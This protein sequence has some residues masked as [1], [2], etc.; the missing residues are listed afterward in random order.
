[1]V[2]AEITIKNPLGLHARPATRLTAICQKFSCDIELQKGTVSIQ[3]KS[4]ISILSG[5]VKQGTKLT[6]V[7]NG[8]DEQEANRAVREY[9]ENLTE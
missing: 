4:I 6:V 2:S 5:A 3:P 7:T 9:L 8:P 1:M